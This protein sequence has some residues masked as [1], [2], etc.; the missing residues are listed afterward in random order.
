MTAKAEDIRAL[1]PL[2]ESILKDESLCVLGNAQKCREDAS[3]F[4]ELCSLFESSG[5]NR[6]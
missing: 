3:V 1:A 4:G 6:Q 2:V 5:E